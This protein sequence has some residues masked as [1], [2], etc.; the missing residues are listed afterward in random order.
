MQLNQVGPYMK[1]IQANVV[2]V[3]AEKIPQMI[4]RNAADLSPWPNNNNPDPFR[5]RIRPDCRR[6]GIQATRPQHHLSTI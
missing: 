1:T 6:N 4:S 3:A 2:I 5:L